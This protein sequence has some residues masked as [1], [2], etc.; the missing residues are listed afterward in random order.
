[1]HGKSSNASRI[2]GGKPTSSFPREIQRV[3]PSTTDHKHLTHHRAPDIT[4]ILQA[5]RMKIEYL[6]HPSDKIIQRVPRSTSDCNHGTHHRAPE[7]RFN[8]SRIAGGNRMPRASVRNLPPC[9]NQQLVRAP[10]KANP[11]ST[12]T[13]SR[14]KFSDRTVPAAKF[15]HVQPYQLNHHTKLQCFCAGYVRSTHARS[16]H[17]RKTSLTN[18]LNAVPVLE[19]SLHANQSPAIVLRTTPKSKPL[20]RSF[21]YPRPPCSVQR[22]KYNRW[23]GI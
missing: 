21:Q 9:A 13:L 17:V 20:L 5:L 23:L 2:L 8:T 10:S 7:N 11:H 14:I 15:N 16:T 3:H 19:F 6:A 18:M 22:V 12:K 4:S 1:M